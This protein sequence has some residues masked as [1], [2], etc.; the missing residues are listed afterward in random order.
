MID[1]NLAH[2]MSRYAQEMDTIAKVGWFLARQP[3]VHLMYERSRLERVARSL[4]PQMLLR[5]AA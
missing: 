3:S 2:H 1:Q 5:D 4:I